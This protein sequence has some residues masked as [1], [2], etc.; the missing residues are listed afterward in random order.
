M[1]STL[2]I[3]ITH[4]Q[5]SLQHGS[6]RIWG[7]PLLLFAFVAYGTLYWWSQF[8]WYLP[9]GFM[10]AGFVLL[11][12][13]FWG[14]LVVAEQISRITVGNNWYWLASGE[15]RIFA[16]TNLL[17]PVAPMIVA[18]WY[19]RVFPRGVAF[20]PTD[21]GVMFA[22][23]FADAIACG[24]MNSTLVFTAFFEGYFDHSFDGPPNWSRLFMDVT[25]GNAAGLLTL[26]PAFIA[27]SRM[28]RSDW[29]RASAELLRWIVPACAIFVLL[30][31]SSVRG[32]PN[33]YLRVLIHLPVVWVA[34]RNGWKIA[35]IALCLTSIVNGIETLAPYTP[36]HSDN[37]GF[38][39]TSQLVL[40][41]VGGTSLALGAA[42]TALRDRQAE[43]ERRNA[44][45]V[46]AGQANATLANEL[47]EAAQR[48]LQLEATQRREIATA[49]HDE[50]GQNLTAMTI[51][52]KLTQ[53]QLPDPSA[54]DPVR[55]VIDSMRHSVRRLLD[56]LSPAALDEFGLHRALVE[57]PVRAMVEDAGLRWQLHILGDP[58]LM[59][60]FP[61]HD[62]SAVYRIVQ[63][64]ATNSVRHARA[65]T[66][67]VSMRFGRRRGQHLLFLTL[68]DDGS[69]IQ[70]VRQERRHY[71]LQG[72][73][74][75]VLAANGVMHLH[76]DEGGTRLHVML[77]VE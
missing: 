36:A 3:W 17:Q 26:F 75:R 2:R 38:E 55:S 42:A 49:L 60:Q 61:Q 7:L 11:P 21:I 77:R 47:R 59:E 67:S 24:L 12:Y 43:L 37:P 23:L 6:V 46:M 45:L 15:Y 71:G 52:L 20:S 4:F 63:E 70:N 14:V 30:S 9:A 19:R 41:A 10:L 29:R 31:Q 27:A 58:R 73:R 28:S 57:G 64:A 74:D 32:L 18:A 39:I 1:N 22:V 72:I 25:I 8:F 68:A 76:S 33:E 62:Q 48:N 54:L 66:F 69:G 16:V 65:T 44:E 34:W 51:R 35:A 56:S 5:S 40:W 50:F 53:Q 13:R